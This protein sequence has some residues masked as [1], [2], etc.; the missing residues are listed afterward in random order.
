[1]SDDD[2]I[3]RNHQEAADAIGMGRDAIRGDARKKWWPGYPMTVR[4]LKELRKLNVGKQGGNHK[5]PPAAKNPDGTYDPD[6]DA[7]VTGDSPWLEEYRKW[8][9]EYRRIQVFEKQ[10]SLL[11][12]DKTRDALTE[13]A[14]LIRGCCEALATRFG[15][16]AADLL[17]QTLDQVEGRI[18]SLCGDCGDGDIG[19]GG[20]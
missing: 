6:L 1:M 13:M 4:Q 10:G 19:A 3:L 7:A 15:Q 16:D 5:K 12:R 20:E 8:N 18:G 9:A 14:S 11:P 2:R 17:T